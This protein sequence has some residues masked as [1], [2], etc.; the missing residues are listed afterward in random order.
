MG[1]AAISVRGVLPAVTPAMVSSATVSIA[2]RGPVARVSAL[3]WDKA[4]TRSGPVHPRCDAE[5]ARNRTGKA[6]EGRRR[7]EPSMKT[8]AGE[9]AH[10]SA[11]EAAGMLPGEVLPESTR[12]NSQNHA[13][14]RCIECTRTNDDLSESSNGW[15][16]TAFALLL[17]IHSF[18]VPTQPGSLNATALPQDPFRPCTRQE[19]ETGPDR[20]HSVGCS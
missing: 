16:F 20:A 8:S 14:R 2:L 10:M 3:P 4:V 12:N 17:Q 6:S 7:G 18:R 1:I 11:A 19:P 5:P 9:P 13:K 15:R